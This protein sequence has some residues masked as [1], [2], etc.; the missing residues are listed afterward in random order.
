MS[1]R[2]RRWSP[3]SVMRQYSRYYD[4]HEHERPVEYINMMW[5]IMREQYKRSTARLQANGN[6][7]GPKKKDGPD[8]EHHHA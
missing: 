6:G 2:W 4:E 3:E 8:L 1:Y 7:S 5:P